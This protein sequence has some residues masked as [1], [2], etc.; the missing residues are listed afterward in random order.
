MVIVASAQI[1]TDK[2]VVSL[3]G[4]WFLEV[5]P[6]AA[7]RT[8]A[9]T[10]HIACATVVD[11]LTAAIPRTGKCARRSDNDEPCS[12]GDERKELYAEFFNCSSLLVVKP[13]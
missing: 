7:E 6:T 13:R 3:S 4:A 9:A 11:L 8:D 2:E 10:V 12:E 1:V 5:S